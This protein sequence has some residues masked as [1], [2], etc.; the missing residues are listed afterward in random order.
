M[1]YTWYSFS[2]AKSAVNSFSSAKKYVDDTLRKTTEKAP[3]PNEAVQWLRQ[4]ASGYAGLIPGAQQYVDTT[5][6]ELEKVSKD[7]KDEVNKIVQDAYKELSKISKEEGASIGAVA[8]AWQVLQSAAKDVA[9]LAKDVGQ[10]VMKRHPEVQEKFGGKFDELK[11]MGDQYGPE[12]KKKVDETWNQIQDVVKGG[13]G[14]GSLDQI[15]KIIEE[16]IQDV[17]KLGDQA[18]D[19]GLEQAKPYLDKAPKVKE[20]V[21]KNKDKLKNSN[22]NDLWDQVRKAAESGDTKDL[23]KLAKEKADQ[24][25]QQLGGG[26]LDQYFKMIPNAGDIGQKFQD[27]KQIGDKHGEK[28]EKLLKEA[29]EDIK[30]VLEKK[31]DEGKKIADEAKEDAKDAK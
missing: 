7:H 12:A 26:S 8:K 24:A 3:A 15:R 31:L 1:Q 5:F 6:D 22:L 28:A 9:E 11:K 18:W 14:V 19:K 2:G 4:T 23:E 20:F 27:L 25:S 13:I 30:K 10:D 21:E 29:F 17:R 16:K